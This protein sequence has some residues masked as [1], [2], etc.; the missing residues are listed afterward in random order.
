MN[1][2]I[3]NCKK[4]TRD[5]MLTAGETVGLDLKNPIDC[6]QMMVMQASTETMRENGHYGEIYLL[7]KSVLHA[8]V[9]N[10]KDERE[11]LTVTFE[12][13]SQRAPKLT[14]Q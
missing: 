9:Y 1:D 11:E 6:S 5:L 3:S 8:Y 2:F 10:D 4:D 14:K 7:R 13:K 12:L